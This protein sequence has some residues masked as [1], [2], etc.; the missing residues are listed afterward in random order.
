[1]RRHRGLGR[2][3]PS[4]DLPECRLGTQRY[5]SKRGHPINRPG[6]EVRLVH[7]CLRV[8]G[9]SPQA[10][11]LALAGI[12]RLVCSPILSHTGKESLMSHH[13]NLRQGGFSQSR[14]RQ[15]MVLLLVVVLCCL[16]STEMVSAGVNVWTGIGPEGAQV[17]S[18]AI[19]PTAPIILYAATSNGGVFKTTNGGSSWSSVNVGLTNTNVSVVAIDPLTPTTLYAGTSGSGVFKSIDAGGSWRVINDGLTDSYVTA[20]AVNPQTPST[21]YVGTGSGVFKTTDGGNRWS[22]TG[23]T[24]PYRG[25]PGYAIRALILNPRTPSILYVGTLFGDLCVW[26]GCLGGSLFKSDDGG[27]SWSE[28]VDVPVFALAID[29]QTPTIL[30]VATGYEVYRDPDCVGDCLTSRG[31]LFKI[32]DGG[33]KWDS[34]TAV[35]GQ[36]IYTLAIDPSKPTNVYAGTDPPGYVFKSTDGGSSWSAFNTGLT[37]PVLS[38]AID[39]LTPTTVYAGTPGGVFTVTTAGSVTL[40][41]TGNPGSGPYAVEAQTTLTGAL[42]VNFFVDGSLFHQESIAKYCLFGGDAACVTGTL[43]AGAHT[44]KARVLAQGTTMVLAETQITLTEGASPPPGTVTL[45]V[46]GNPGSGPY[47]VEAQTTLPGALTV[48][49]VVDGSL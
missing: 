34:W 2:S 49:F 24:D 44:I 12:R 29:P 1:M 23:L 39:P 31:G 11:K 48:N 9:S 8:A 33:D 7:G 32:T 22:S 19:D 38:L 40:V 21:I 35:L 46:M 28:T 41:V 10:A 15:R 30:Y 3:R 45:V 17:T 26:G 6:R 37:Q 47:A 4:S 16:G 20:L 36:T 14:R 18:L 42:T 25:A 43:G 27:G 5:G 13:A